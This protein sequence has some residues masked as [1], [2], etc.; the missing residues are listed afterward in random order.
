M[1]PAVT[2]TSAIEAQLLLAGRRVTEV[3]ATSIPTVSLL[4]TPIYSLFF[5]N[6]GNGM[7]KYPLYGNKAHKYIFPCSWKTEAL[8]NLY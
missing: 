2:A 4:P 3:M 8:P 1:L 7:C 5:H 6:P